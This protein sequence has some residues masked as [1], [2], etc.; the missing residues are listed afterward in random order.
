[1]AIENEEDGAFNEA[2]SGT[3]DTDTKP[4]KPQSFKEAFAAARSGGG[5]TFE[6]NGKKYTTDLAPA[7][8]K[9]EGMSMTRMDPEKARAAKRQGELE[10]MR[11]TALRRAE[12]ERAVKAHKERQKTSAEAA[13]AASLGGYKRGGSVKSSASSRGDGIASRGKTRGRIC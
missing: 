8:P 13:A 12:G 11:D 9:N 10:V 7:K 6:W 5:K 2:G 4:T 1:M 3:N